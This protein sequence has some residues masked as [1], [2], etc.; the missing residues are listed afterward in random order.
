MYV[1]EANRD[2]RGLG[3]GLRRGLGLGLRRG[4]GHRLSLHF[5]SPPTT[6]ELLSR[7]S[8]SEQ[9]QNK[10]PPL[11]QAEQLIF[12]LF[13]FTQYA[14]I[15]VDLHIVGPPP[16]PEEGGGG[17]HCRHGPDVAAH[18]QARPG[19]RPRDVEVGHL[20]DGSVSH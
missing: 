19:R 13:C 10:P 3:L 11:F 9:L 7:S 1:V 15:S 17:G 12:N 18:G 5:P 16:D 14:S 2:R 6:M 20:D 4:L 8:V